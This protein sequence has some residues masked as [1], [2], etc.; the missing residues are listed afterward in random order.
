MDG[1]TPVTLSV[2]PEVHY[3]GTSEFRTKMTVGR[4]IYM[5]IVTEKQ[6]WDFFFLTE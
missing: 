6:N 5:F 1:W 3:L 2:S 4:H